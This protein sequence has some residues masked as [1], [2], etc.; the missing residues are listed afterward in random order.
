MNA[1]ALEHLPRFPHDDALA[2]DGW[3]D[4]SDPGIPGVR[5]FARGDA[6]V[7][8]MRGVEMWDLLLTRAGTVSHSLLHP[9][10]VS[11]VLVNLARRIPSTPN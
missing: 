4:V 3:D 6:V 11:E 5:L 2:R 8:L 7:V 10:E 9:E 1:P